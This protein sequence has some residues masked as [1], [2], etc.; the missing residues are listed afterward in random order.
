MPRNFE[1][2]RVL[3][4]KKLRL[5]RLL[6]ITL[7]ALSSQNVMAQVFIDFF[8]TFNM[9][10]NSFRPETL[11][12][13][14]YF[15]YME[16]PR[17][18]QIGLDL[19]LKGWQF[20]GRFEM[21]QNVATSINGGAW[22]NLPLSV[23]S[24]EAKTGGFASNFPTEGWIAYTNQDVDFSVGRRTLV[25]GPGVYNFTLGEQALP[26]DGY[27]INVHPMS[28]YDVRF[29][30][31]FSGLF[32][33]TRA[34][35]LFLD[36]NQRYYDEN[37]GEWVEGYDPVTAHDSRYD[38]PIKMFFTHKLGAE[39]DW[40][41]IG[42]AESLMI[43]GGFPGFDLI[44]PMT[45][46]HNGFLD[47]TN[48]LMELSFE[49]KINK[50][51]KLQNEGRVYGAFALDDVS[52]G[53]FDAAKPTAFGL[54]LGTQ[55]Q[56]IEGDQPYIGTIQSDSQ[57]AARESTFRFDKGLTLGVEMVWT[58]KY[59]YSRPE[60]DPFGKMT[61]MTT[62]QFGVNQWPIIEYNMG[63]PY[64]GDVFLIQT[65]IDYIERFWHLR[66]SLGYM[67]EGDK[68]TGVLWT[69]DPS[70]SSPDLVPAGANDDWLGLSGYLTHSLIMDVKAYYA[71]T[72]W[73]QAYVGLWQRL[74]M[75]DFKESRIYLSMGF[76]FYFDTQYF[77]SDQNKKY[78]PE[79]A[80]E[81]V[82]ADV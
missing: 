33:M 67:I 9:G 72:Q 64:G 53:D 26:S 48:A 24:G 59:F 35:D 50:S 5:Y 17:L 54:M 39:G 47:N 18:L 29:V 3:R 27:W 41:R 28:E 42:L 14:Y 43:Y 44:S 16:Q 82:K 32:S 61:M 37:T 80:P 34:N 6:Y 56:L 81:G 65:N 38:L 1:P 68:G 55:W 57:H 66:A 70:T 76:H 31:V 23:G 73:F 15:M 52:L 4:L 62:T 71:V 45:S 19:S 10:S 7:M 75:D 30:G 69:D 13:E 60:D 21:F 2:Q 78:K 11:T 74:R 51:G 8:P 79:E 63:F 40:W 77:L 46:W 49:F 22:S 36:A 58:T 25:M 20:Y 12:R